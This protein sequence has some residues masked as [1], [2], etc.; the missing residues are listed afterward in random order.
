MN[1][2]IKRVVN[3]TFSNECDGD[4]NRAGAAQVPVGNS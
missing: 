2:E 3:V 1:P 4:D